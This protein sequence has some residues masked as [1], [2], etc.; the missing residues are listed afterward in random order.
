[1]L[2]IFEEG[3]QKIFILVLNM[4]LTGS[5]VIAAVLPARLLLKK[6]PRIFSYGLWAAVLFRLLCPVSFSLPVSLLGALQ[7]K[8][9]EAGRMEY[10]AEDIGYWEKPQ[11]DL[12]VPGISETVNEYLPLEDR[13]ASVN[14][15]QLYL[16]AGAY[17]WLLGALSMGVY[18]VLSLWR[19]K[20]RLGDAV[21]EKD[22][23]Y[24]FRKKGSPF[25]CGLFRPR[26]YL[27]EQ[28][29]E[30]EEQ[31]ILLHEQIHIKRGDAVFR[32]FACLA[33][34]LH[35]FN[36]L[37]WAAF[38]LSGRDMEMSCDEAVIRRLGSKVKKEYS[39]SLLNMAAGGKIVKGVPLAFGESDTGS[40]IKNVLRYQ[41]STA[42]LVG[43]AALISVALSVIFLANPAK[44][45]ENGN[46]FYGVV[47]QAVGVDGGEETVLRIPGIGDVMLPEAEETSLYLERDAEEIIMPGDILRITFSREKE[48]TVAAAEQNGR[49]L[50]HFVAKPAGEAESIQVMGEGFLLTRQEGDRYLFTVP[51]GMADQAQAGD[52]LEIYHDPNADTTAEIYLSAQETKPG[53]VLLAAPEVLSV[54]AAHYDIWVELSAQETETFLSEFGFGITAELIQAQTPAGGEETLTGVSEEPLGEEQESAEA[55]YSDARSEGTDSGLFS[56]SP[57]RLENGELQDGAYV[58]YV[59]SIS[60]S[61]RGFD[62]YVTQEE[63]EDLPLFPFAEKCE[64]RVNWEKDKLSY[65]PVSFDKFADLV[66]QS[67]RVINPP[68]YCEVRD[69]LIVRADLE[70][71]YYVNGFT[72]E[73]PA[74]G[75]LAWNQYA[76]N[77]GRDQHMTAEEVL[78]NYYTLSHTESADIGDGAGVEQIEVYTGNIGDGGSGVVLFKDADGAVLGSEF[79]HAAR[80]GWNNIYI[81]D[82]EGVNYILTV[83]IEDR[84]T[85]GEYSYQV[86]RFGEGRFE[87]SNGRDGRLAEAGEIRQIAGSRFEFGDSYRYDDEMFRAWADDLTY[88]LKNSH[89]VLSSQEGEIRTE[90]VSEA[91]KY[92]YET[93]RRGL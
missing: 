21:W 93:L 28:M 49:T 57:E 39:A 87:E 58:V 37:V 63:Y 48:I 14:P 41:K 24:R 82:A 43:G 36:P 17:V 59:Q 67:A 55:S 60:N 81:G 74:D 31:Y 5:V 16:T 79:A 70:S 72:Y 47:T 10:I 76:E 29:R 33:L 7:N 52:I 30:E 54:D 40:R 84:D 22:N 80:A 77:A 71:G 45:K 78:E 65:S 68:V 38:M 89:L 62:R 75:S 90:T 69:N 51:L 12:P 1:M 15:M 35:W 34:W 4:T 19:F 64:F 73:R 66:T 26:I 44:A 3:L 53:Q 56:L 20:K 88:Y 92:N 91:D 85:Y 42:L 46:I 32:L 23:I 18:S 27:P 83:H 86:Y 9:A 11:V 8:P 50:Y 6:A 13:E 25:V 61:A 2:Q